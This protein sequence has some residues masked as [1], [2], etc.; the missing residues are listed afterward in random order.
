MS[1]ALLGAAFAAPLAS[2]DLEADEGGFSPSSGDLHWAWGEPAAGPGGGHDSAACWATNPDGLYLNDAEGSLQL[3]GVDLSGVAAPVLSYWQW[4]DIQPGDAGWI[5]VDSGGGWQRVEPIYGYPEDAGFVGDSQGWEQ[6]FVDLSGLAASDQVRFTFSSDASVSGTG[7]YLDDLTLHDTDVVPPRIELLTLPSDTEDLDGPYLVEATARDDRGLASVD[8]RWSVDGGVAQSVSMIDQGGHYEGNIPGQAPGSIVS[9][10][11]EAEDA[12]NLSAS[13]EQSFE[14]RLLPPTDLLGPEGRL[15]AVEVE[16]AW[17]APESIH[18][19]EGYAVYRDGERLLEVDETRAVVPAEGGGEAFAVSAVYEVGESAPSEELFLDISRPRLTRVDPDSAW[20]GD[21]LRVEIFGE[22]LLLEQDDVELDPGQGIEVLSLEVIDVD[23]L[24]AE[25]VVAED[26]Q[27]GLRELALR[28]G[29]V[30]LLDEFE[31]FDGAGR[32]RIQS[33][34]PDRIRQGESGTFVLRTSVELVSEE[35]TV[36]LGEGVVVESIEI[37]AERE[38]Q[39][40]L[41]VDPLA[42]LG[43]RP[44]V[45]DD[46][47]RLYEGVTLRVRDAAVTQSKNC[48][49]AG[50]AGPW[51][52]GLVLL[53]VRRFRR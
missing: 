34:E 2:W 47:S 50:I 11:V 22:H 44:V 41:V 51:L 8:L 31:V 12:F 15:V 21:T 53:G 5:E 46:G 6:V 17:S 10:W 45:V 28:S 29:E 26:A 16:L 36:D 13:E 49:S 43:E 19:L 24:L 18:T 35:L 9:W 32:P 37:S 48:N 27:L 38:V 23:L 52:L 42:P 33:I 1:W 7:W 39:L 20:Q 40:E 3:P 14:V 30:E 25:L 4:T